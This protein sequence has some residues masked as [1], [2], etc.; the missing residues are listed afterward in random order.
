MRLKK[1][2]LDE[3]NLNLAWKLVET[4]DAEDDT[5]IF[6]RMS[7]SFHSTPSVTTTCTKRGTLL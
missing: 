5:K 2:K 7:T 3:A 4:Y 6:V 1:T